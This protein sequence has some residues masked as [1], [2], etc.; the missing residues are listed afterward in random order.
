MDARYLASNLSPHSSLTP[1]SDDATLFTPTTIQTVNDT[2]AFLQKYWKALSPST[3][4]TI[5]NLY[6]SS[7]FLPNITAGLSSEYYRSSRIFRDILLTCPS[8]LVAHAMSL[9]YNNDTTPAPIYLYNHN[10]TI[11]STYLDS[12]GDPG[13]GV[14]H[15]S[16]L[17]YV[18]GNFTPYCIDETIHPSAH[19][20]EL[21]R[22]MVGSW[23][24][25]AYTGNPTGN[26][27]SLR[28]WTEA[29]KSGDTMMDA[30]V[31]VSGGPYPGISRL[32]GDESVL[33]GVVE[34]RLGER[35]GFLNS[36]EVVGELQY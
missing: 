28:G 7:S 19:D 9:K 8:F 36:L 27:T 20:Y 26:G 10:Q 34:Q 32:S 17:A 21:M 5:L 6:P 23:T 18:F 22:Q 29:Y 14:I 4:T 1:I 3:I 11:L 24:A 35:C 12:I 13:F 16:D 25:F 2:T 31:Y 30:N 15:T 33:S